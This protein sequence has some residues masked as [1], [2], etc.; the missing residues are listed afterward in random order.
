MAVF[1]GMNYLVWLILQSITA[2]VT[3]ARMGQTQLPLGGFMSLVGAHLSI[4]LTLK[5][6]FLLLW[7]VMM[8]D[9]AELPM[10]VQSFEV[11]KADCY[12]CSVN[13]ELP[14]GTEIPCDR[15]LIYDVLAKWYGNSGSSPNDDSHLRAFNRAAR[16]VLSEEVVPRMRNNAL[17]AYLLGILVA[18]HGFVLS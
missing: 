5:P 10:Q 1:F 8:K 18:E 11:Q 3:F 9:V 16:E 15:R 12:C 7:M 14:D 13:H 17:F 6:A 2:M 4:S